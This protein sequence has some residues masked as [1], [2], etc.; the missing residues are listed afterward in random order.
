MA[1]QQALLS[2]FADPTRQ[3]VLNL[4]RR[5]SLTV[6]E[7]ADRLPVSRPAVSQ[8]LRVL[9]NA[10]LVEVSHRG[11]RHYFSLNPAKLSEL[12]GFIDAMW[13]D[14]LVAFSDSVE[15]EARKRARTKT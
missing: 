14:A 2:A 5:K 3:A 9:E 13:R 11:T 6:G 8:H 10:G 12:R 1:D 7:L 4:L 15:K